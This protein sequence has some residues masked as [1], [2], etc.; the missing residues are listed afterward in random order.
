MLTGEFQ[1]IFTFHL[2]L[3]DAVANILVA[4]LCGSLIS[5]LY[6]WTYKGLNYS[7]SFSNSLV[8]LAMITALVIMVI[9]NNLA[10]AFG[11]VGAMS[12]IRFRTAVKDAQD[13]M[14][15]FFSLAIGLAA[16][17]KL[18]AIAVSSTLLVGSVIWLMSKTRLNAPVKREY[19]LHVITEQIQEEENTLL[20]AKLKEY[21]SQV[22]LINVRT[23]GEAGYALYEHSYYVRIRRENKS[24]IF[25]QQLQN[26]RGV[27]QVNLFFDEE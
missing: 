23:L 18:Y 11:L 22:K 3:R 6:R 7:T 1:E 5:L 25:V 2:S 15:I 10:R 14:F 17:V 9:G 20:T 13:I 24:S 12:I 27:K 19:L 8:M 21:C 26:I 4:L 16:G